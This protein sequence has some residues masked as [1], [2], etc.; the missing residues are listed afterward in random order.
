MSQ[1]TYDGCVLILTK[2]LDSRP[3][4]AHE[5]CMLPLCKA[6][7]FVHACLSAVLRWQIV[8]A[9]IAHAL[10]VLGLVHRPHG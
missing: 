5:K 3:G 2:D 7:C 6:C 10:L 8:A 1:H 9:Y 4:G